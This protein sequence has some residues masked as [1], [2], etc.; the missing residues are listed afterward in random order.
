MNRE[1][2]INLI[3]LLLINLLIKP[4]YTFGIDLR[5]QNLVGT[6][7]Y[8][9]Y[10]ALFNFSYI[11]QIFGDLGL[12]Q[13]NNRNIA[14]NGFLIDKYLPHILILKSILAI[15][16]IGIGLLV[17]IGLGYQ[18][19]SLY[20]LTFLL[21]NQILITFLFFL[22]S[23]ISGL[24]YYRLDSFFSALD[25]LLMVLICGVLVWTPLSKDFRIEWFL[26]AQTTAY[27]LSVLLAFWVNLRFLKR[28]LH[29]HF[30]WIVLLA[31][32]KKSLP[33]ALV[34]ILMTLYTRIDA[35]MIERLLDGVEGKK[36]AGIYAFAYRFL[37]TSNMFVYLF[38]TLLL[39]MFS[40]LLSQQAAL[41]AL[42][43]F[44]YQLM[45]VLT[46]GLSI[47]LAYY[48][49]EIGQALFDEYTPYTAE[50]FAMLIL[51]FNALGMLAIFGTLLT[52]N[53]SLRAMNTLFVIGILLNVL[54]NYI[55]IPKYGAWGAALSTL[56]TQS[57][58]ALGEIFLVIR[59]FQLKVNYKLI[60][61]TLSFI[62]LVLV[63]TYY[64]YHYLEVF[65]FWKF[66]MTGIMVLIFAFAVQ[67]ISIKEFVLL[68]S[69]KKRG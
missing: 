48:A 3:L 35:V 50:V 25:K 36:E 7:S 8:G 53:G 1:F 12:Q 39:P 10:F 9:L 32:L 63:G 59:I 18:A 31:I 68:L 17:A 49:P 41:K 27:G 60:T 58:V 13:Y 15:L 69:I 2:L 43:V 47:G 11:F 33:F 61:Q 51:S 14:Q 52:A 6:Q 37:D 34:V 56:C 19:E 42:L 26:Y 30:N 46:I 16:V 40:R 67:L 23:N 65:W 21:F 24:G 22:R 44:S 54:M 4:F 66:S 45:L 57:F 5:V 29:F 64:L 28:K 38:A 55:M 20:L 62:I